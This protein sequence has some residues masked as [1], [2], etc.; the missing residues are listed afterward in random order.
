MITI[1]SKSKAL[2]REHHL[3]CTLDELECELISAAAVFYAAVIKKQNVLKKKIL[4]ATLHED[5]EEVTLYTNQY[6]ELN[7]I[8]ES[9]RMKSVREKIHSL[10]G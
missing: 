2:V 6:L 1:D 3:A 8:D 5:E 7:S 4:I 9:P 10:R